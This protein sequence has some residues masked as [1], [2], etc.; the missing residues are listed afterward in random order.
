MTLQ[1]WAVTPEV[2][3]VTLDPNDEPYDFTLQARNWEGKQLWQI[4]V[5]YSEPWGLAAG[6]NSVFLGSDPGAIHEYDLAS[7]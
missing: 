2:I 5:A 3:V 4:V 7:G 1:Q 6:G